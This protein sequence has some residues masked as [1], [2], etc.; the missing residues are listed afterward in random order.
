MKAFGPMCNP[1]LEQTPVP[2]GAVCPHCRELF[3]ESDSGV[4]LNNNMTAMHLECFMRGIL[5]SVAHQRRRCHCYGGHENDSPG[6][7]IRQAAVAAY[8]E[9][10]SQL[11]EQAEASITCPRCGRTSWNPNDVLNRYCGACH[12][13]HDQMEEQNQ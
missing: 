11:V 12:L 13:F 2:L 10:Q 4:W 7:T 6:L 8:L 9:Y 3:S 1:S 5:G